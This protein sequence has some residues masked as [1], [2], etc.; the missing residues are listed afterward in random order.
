MIIIFTNQERSSMIKRQKT[1]REL[2][3]EETKQRI[4]KAVNRLIKYI[5][6]DKIRVKD[7]C[8]E[9]NVSVG[10]F[11]HYFKS[12]DYIALVGYDFDSSMARILQDNALTGDIKSKILRLFELEMEYVI[13]SGVHTMKTLFQ[14]HL[15]S[16]EDKNRA[17]LNPDRL[18]P[19]ILRK[20]FLRAIQEG[21]IP[22]LCNVDQVVEDILIISRSLTYHWCIK[23]GDDDLIERTN[24]VIGNYLDSIL[25]H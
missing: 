3:A 12:K 20:L 14:S 2:Q 21:E 6:Y 17:F 8:E 19:S 15:D 23:N 16:I 22:S 18:L 5:P 9:A 4:V 10:T 25:S 11:Y 24:R 13:D 7:I 1:K